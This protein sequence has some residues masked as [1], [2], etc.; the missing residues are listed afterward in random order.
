V[1]PGTGDVDNVVPL[2]RG[3]RSVR[4]RP[5]RP[6]ID[7]AGIRQV[8][9][10]LEDSAAALRAGP[11]TLLRPRGQADPP[12]VAF[13]LQLP[14]VSQALGRLGRIDVTNWP[15]T[16][17]V[18]QIRSACAAAAR[19]LEAVIRSLR[20]TPPGPGMLDERLSSDIDEFA[21]ALRRLRQLISQSSVVA[22]GGT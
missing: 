6:A 9:Q 4:G 12:I 13:Q 22:T 19:R 1:R 20:R 3:R 17:W 8:F 5:A 15:D 11:V 18:L 16:T 14:L 10:G 7:L 2:R 21:A